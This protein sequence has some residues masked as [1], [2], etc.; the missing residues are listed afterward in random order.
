ML[1]PRSVETAIRILDVIKRADIEWVPGTAVCEH[2]GRSDRTVETILARLVGAGIL[3]GKRGPTGG[4]KQVLETSLLE[5]FFLNAPSCC[6]R[7]PS[8]EE[9]VNELQRKILHL[10]SD[11]VF[12]P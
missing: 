10:Y 3:E 6:Q 5:L 12:V 8:V 1:I 11:V 2:V 9:N 4:Y 7:A